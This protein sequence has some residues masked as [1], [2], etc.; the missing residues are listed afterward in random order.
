MSS[1]E[2]PAIHSSSVSSSIA[3]SIWFNVR[4]L[5]CCIGREVT[6]TSLQPALQLLHQALP[7][8]QITSI[9]YT[10]LLRPF[11]TELI[12]TELTQTEQEQ[13][14]KS[15]VAA[16]NQSFDAAIIFTAPFQSPYTIAYLCYLAGIP[17]RIGQSCEFGGTVLSTCVSPP[18]DPVSPT[19]YHLHLLRSI[20]ISP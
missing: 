9:N 11:Q 8:V 6:A 7:D 18:V 13:S 4:S 10:E 17:V 14:T 5:L 20:G 15:L 2:L 19:Q 12:H 3:S 16:L 1:I